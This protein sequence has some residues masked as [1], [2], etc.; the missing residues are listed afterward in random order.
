V[1]RELQIGL[2]GGHAGAEAR[3]EDAHGPRRLHE[4]HLLIGG[5]RGARAELGALVELGD[6]AHEAPLELHAVMIGEG[7]THAHEGRDQLMN[8]HAEGEAGPLVA[9]V[10]LRRAVPVRG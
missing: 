8:A 6:E 3:A 4:E 2:T 7:L 1:L 9:L 5:R 10:G